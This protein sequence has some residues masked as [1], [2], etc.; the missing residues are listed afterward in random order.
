MVWLN[1][2]SDEMELPKGLPIDCSPYLS[3]LKASP[4]YQSYESAGSFS[5]TGRQTMPNNP[6]STTNLL[7]NRYGT[8]SFNTQFNSDSTTELNLPEPCSTTSLE[9]TFSQQSTPFVDGSMITSQHQA[10][11]QSLMYNSNYYVTQQSFMPWQQYPSTVGSNYPG[12]T[13]LAQGMSN[14]PGF[15]YPVINNASLAAGKHIHYST[16]PL[17]LSFSYF[18]RNFIHSFIP[19][20]HDSFTFSQCKKLQKHLTSHKKEQNFAWK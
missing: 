17:L 7:P 19:S 14:T 2:S 13:Y 5:P 18:C 11:T 1:D 10:S 16:S 20:L 12:Y 4:S 3:G 15:G 8:Q 9:T 6:L